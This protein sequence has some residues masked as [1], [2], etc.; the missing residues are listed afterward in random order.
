MGPRLDTQ[1]LFSARDQPSSSR[2]IREMAN[3]ALAAQDTSSTSATI[4]A[5]VQRGGCITAD[6]VYRPLMDDKNDA[7]FSKAAKDLPQW[8]TRLTPEEYSE[9][10]PGADINCLGGTYYLMSQVTGGVVEPFCVR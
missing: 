4:A 1:P 5:G 9:A 10:V 3:A 7:A 8:V 2:R 6:R